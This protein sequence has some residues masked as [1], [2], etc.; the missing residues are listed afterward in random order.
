[1]H[2]WH[3]SVSNRTIY[4]CE[5]AGGTKIHI[6]NAL[7]V[8]LINVCPAVR[9]PNQSWMQVCLPSTSAL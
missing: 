5:M 2:R 4:F 3:V 6:P 7:S 9:S 1:M 8:M